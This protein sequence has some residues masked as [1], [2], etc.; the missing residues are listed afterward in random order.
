VFA[1]LSYVALGH[2]HGQQDVSTGTPRTTVRYCGSPLAFSFSERHHVKSVTLVDVDGGG[3]VRTSKLPAPVPRPLREVRGK[4]DVLLAGADTGRKPDAD[5]LARSW[6]RVVLT[7]TVRPAAPMERLRAKWPHTL[8]LDFAPEGDLTSPAADLRRV[9]RTADPV[10]ICGHFVEFTSGGI[11]DDHQRTLLRDVVETVLAT[12]RD[13]A[14][15]NGS[16]SRV[17]DDLDEA[18]SIDAWLARAGRDDR[19]SEAVRDAKGQ[20]EA[21]GKIAAA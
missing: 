7:D 6:L 1:G 13:V 2:L 4:L 16:A 12:E 17:P 14:A 21:G 20:G 3:R 15:G 9:A 8:V 10:Q 11:A 19:L 18:G 5:D